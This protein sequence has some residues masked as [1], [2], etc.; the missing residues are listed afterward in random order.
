MGRGTF[1]CAPV[2]HKEIRFW[3]GFARGDS[4]ESGARK[5]TVSR[6]NLAWTCP[7]SQLIRAK[8]KA[9]VLAAPKGVESND[10]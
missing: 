1:D 8:K 5:Q 7:D 6:E 3:P 9:I 10:H 2:T 4:E